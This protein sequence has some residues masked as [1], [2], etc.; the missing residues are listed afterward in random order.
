MAQR[1][2]NQGADGDIYVSKKDEM[3]WTSPICLNPPVNT[4]KGED[5][6]VI[7]S[8][9]QTVYFQSWAQGW[10]DNDGPYYKAS[11]KGDQWSASSGLGDSINIF[12]STLMKRDQRV[13]TDG[14]TVSPDGKTFIV[15][16]ANGYT[17][18]MD[19]YLFKKNSKGRWGAPIK[20]SINTSADERSIFMAADGKTIYFASN[21]YG[22]FG[23]L[24]IFKTTIDE[25]GDHGE[26]INIGKPFNTDKDDYGFIVTA[27]GNKAYFVRDGD[28]YSS[29]LS[30]ASSDIKPNPTKL[31]AGTLKDRTG[32]PLSGVIK[33]KKKDNSYIISTKTN[34]STGEYLLTSSLTSGDFELE[35]TFPD[36]TK[37]ST[38]I[39]LK[40]DSSYEE[41]N[42]DYI[43]S[44]GGKPKLEKLST[45]IT[46]YFDY[47]KDLLKEV[48]K[49]TITSR[50]ESFSSDQIKTVQISG[51]TDGDGS[52]AYNQKLGE[53]RARSVSSYLKSVGVKTDR[54]SSF[55]KL[56]PIA[57]NKTDEGKSINR[58]V[59]IRVN[60][61][62]TGL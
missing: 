57:S 39:V 19:F 30:D 8:D 14:M 42:Q 38:P 18:N 10:A 4:T 45:L 36:G 53:N 35:T 9:G 11:L 16:Y 5:E 2:K 27:S 59:E 24:D 52:V 23:G 21:G 3:G 43:Y 26:I 33:L 29:D 58:R 31:F 60:Y 62:F 46:V 48:S 15:A 54:L 51:F 56:K 44:P 17:S 1:Y 41:I 34:T 28:I 6:P 47:N 22:G 7:S 13:A 40:N 37:H 20:L 32:K 50:L 61:D 55:G 12:F 49:T 25:N